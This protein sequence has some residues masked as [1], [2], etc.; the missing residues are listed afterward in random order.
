MNPATATHNMAEKT[1]I[2]IVDDESQITR[3][4]C[5][6]CTAQGYSVKSAADGE[7]ALAV[8]QHWAADLIITDLSMPNLDGVELCRAVRRVSKVPILV[9][10]VRDQEKVKVLALDAGA[11]DYITKPFQMNELLARLRA[12]LRRSTY[13]T[14]EDSSKEIL[15]G[16][17]RIDTSSHQVYVRGQEL[18]LTPKEFDLLHALALH[19]DRV[20]TR[21]TLMTAVWGG[22]NIDQPESLRVL[23]GQLRK[24]IEMDSVTRYIQTEPWVGYRFLPEGIPQD[25]S[26]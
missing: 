17:F 1:K 24:K 7:A 18:H 9:L 22:Y 5:M 4:L 16:D 10:S 14:S 13:A 21:R 8:L 6:A 26:L 2:L 11:D 3:V 25:P 23:I 19:P 20:L 12:A 15:V